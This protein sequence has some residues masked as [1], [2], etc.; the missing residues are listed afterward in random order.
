M[1]TTPPSRKDTTWSV[2][3]ASKT[4]KAAGRYPTY[5]ETARNATTAI[6]WPMEPV[7]SALSPAAF[8][9][10]QLWLELYAPAPTA[11]RATTSQ[12]RLALP[13][14]QQTV[15]YV[16]GIPAHLVLQVTT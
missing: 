5:T 8:Q 4:P 15:Q 9:Q 6:L 16:Q 2:S 11:C 10:I 1:T 7:P 3:P 13:A 14:R 12:L